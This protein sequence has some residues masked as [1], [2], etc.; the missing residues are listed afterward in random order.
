M[1]YTP[2]LLLRMG[3]TDFQHKIWIFG[4][5]KGDKS[6]GKKREV[7]GGF[8]KEKGDGFKKIKEGETAAIKKGGGP[9]SFW[10]RMAAESKTMKKGKDRKDRRETK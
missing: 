5:D 8:G 2:P 6:F 7:F 1:E 9:G 3:L 10:G 4:I